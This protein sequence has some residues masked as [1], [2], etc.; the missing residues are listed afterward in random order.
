MD[1]FK[2]ENKFSL[3]D[4]KEMEEI[5]HNYFPNEN[6]TKAEEVFKWYRK[7]NLTC[8]GIRN[9]E[10]TILGNV[11]ILP[12]KYETFMNIYENKMNE[13]DVI[14]KQIEQYENNKSYYI[15]LSSIS[16]NKNYLNNYK[17]IIKLLNGVVQLLNILE[18]RNI[19]IKMLMADASTIHGEKICQKLLN[20]SFITK[21]SH[22]S[23]IYCI[24][25]QDLERVIDKIKSRFKDKD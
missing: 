19:K 23:K 20:M 15:Y 5:E 7:N 21:T 9:K 3:V 1:A 17:L 13:A 25:G 8:I 11:C 6:I 18:S 10:G 12:L 16:I 22:N 14:A 2:I 24:D 4:F